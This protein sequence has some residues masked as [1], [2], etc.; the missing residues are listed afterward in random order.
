[1]N[2]T[3]NLQE[4]LEGLLGTIEEEGVG[5]LSVC[6]VNTTSRDYMANDAPD[7]AY[8]FVSYA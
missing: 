1:M 7:A 6:G 5:A 4:I 8:T 2:T 3:M